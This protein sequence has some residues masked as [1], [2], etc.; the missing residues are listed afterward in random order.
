MT[1]EEILQYNR[2]CAE[3][4]GW[5]QYL[6]VNE[7][8]YGNWK[9]STTLEKPWSIRVERLFFD[10]DWNW[11]MEVVD[12]IEK[13]NRLNDK[14]YYPYCITIWKNGCAI[15]DGNN[16]YKIVNLLAASKKEAVVEAINKFL[17]WY[18]QNKTK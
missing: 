16:G 11:I 3:F 5:E 18:E 8:F 13:I 17:I 6:D 9:P 14:E 2:M 1:Q 10:S 15:S 7:R 4:L 12:S